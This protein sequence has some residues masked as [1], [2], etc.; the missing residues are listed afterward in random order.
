M[1]RKLP[2]LVILHKHGHLLFLFVENLTGREG[3]NEHPVYY[4]T[5]MW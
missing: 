2:P 3:I 5:G 4:D 1:H